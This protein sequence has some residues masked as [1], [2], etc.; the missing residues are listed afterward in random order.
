MVEYNSRGNKNAPSSKK[1]KPKQ[2]L[3]HNVTRYNHQQ[4]FEDEKD[5]C[6]FLTCVKDCK[7]ISQFD[8]YAYCLMGNH[9]HLLL[10]VGA[11]SLENIVKRIGSKYVYWYNVKY[12][13]I[14]HLFQDR[15]KSEPV[16]SEKYFLTVLRYVHLNPVKAKICKNPEDYIYSSYNQY[17]GDSH[18]IDRDFVYTILPHDYFESFHFE[19][20]DDRCLEIEDNPTVRYTD[21]QAKELIYTYSKCESISA[22][23]KLPFAEKGKYIKKICE[24]GVSIRQ[25]SRLTGESKNIIEKHL[26]N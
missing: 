26:K 8:L 17:L 12:G 4:I 10:K 21:D 22:F 1:K 7:S 24:A 9:V 25:A 13:R 14:G 20:S 16:E 6:E 2:Y 3:P 5:Y 19:E 18:F 15:F 23:Q 11:D